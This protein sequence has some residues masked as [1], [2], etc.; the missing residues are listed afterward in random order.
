MHSWY[1]ADRGHRHPD[2]VCWHAVPRPSLT[3]LGG[4]GH[5]EIQE[6]LSLLP[7]KPLTRHPVT[8]RVAMALYCRPAAEK[9][10]CAALF[11]KMEP[12]RLDRRLPH[13]SASCRLR[14]PLLSSLE[15]SRGLCVHRRAN[16]EGHRDRLGRRPVRQLCVH[17]G[18]DGGCR[19]V[20]E[21]CGSLSDAAALDRMARARL[22][23]LLS[24]STPLRWSSRRGVCSRW[25][26]IAAV[27]AVGHRVV[28]AEEGSSQC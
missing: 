5:E 27:R 28:F 1:Q 12:R 14:F 22:P 6:V 19:L 26:G 24:R 23:R 13:L 10:L 2:C 7:G 20:V 4:R 15:P 16:R 21:R 17:S 3:I 8:V 18:L 25:F 11:S 9:Y